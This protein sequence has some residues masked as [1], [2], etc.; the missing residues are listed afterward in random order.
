MSTLP[1]ISTETPNAKHAALDTYETFA[2]VE[3]FAEDQTIAVAAVVSVAAEIARAVDAAVPRIRAGGRLIYVG[4]GTSGR[5]G[6]L[7]SVELLPTFSWPEDRALAVLAGGRDAV[8]RAVEGAEDDE[9]QGARDVAALNPTANDVVLR[10]AIMHSRSDSR[11][12]KTQR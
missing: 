10:N 2:M 4:A 3:A 5:L 9:A 12:M 6:L 11:I 8:Y 7:D 1:T